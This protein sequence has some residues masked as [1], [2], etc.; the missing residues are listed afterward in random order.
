MVVSDRIALSTQG[1]S[2]LCSTDWATKPLYGGPDG[3]RT[4]KRL[5]LNQ[6]PSD[7][8][9]DELPGCSTPQYGG[10]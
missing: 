3:N 4:R 8:E 5:D 10:C 2:V 9:T 6:R 7:Y 1:F